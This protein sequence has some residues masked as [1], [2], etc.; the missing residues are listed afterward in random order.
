MKSIVI[1]RLVN[2]LTVVARNY[3]RAIA[4]SPDDDN[5]VNDFPEYKALWK[6]V[7]GQKCPTW[8]A[9]LRVYA[10]AVWPGNEEMDPVFLDSLKKNGVTREGFFR[11]TLALARLSTGQVDTPLIDRIEKAGMD[12]SKI[13]SLK[14]TFEREFLIG[15]IGQTQEESV[16]QSVFQL[17]LK[18]GAEWEWDSNLYRFVWCKIDGKVAVLEVA[19]QLA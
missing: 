18:E 14:K 11:A 6:V 19:R 3:R 2:N 13:R 5:A 4:E 8:R 15:R 10:M 1:E 17:L 12:I 9:V 7:E 16:V